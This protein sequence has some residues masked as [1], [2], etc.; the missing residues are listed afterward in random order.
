MHSDNDMIRLNYGKSDTWDKVG[1]AG[2]VAA[3]EAI[4]FIESLNFILA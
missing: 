4:D 1:C 3:N 2:E